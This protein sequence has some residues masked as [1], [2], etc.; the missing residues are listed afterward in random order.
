MGRALF[1][2]IRVNK[3][4]LNSIKFGLSSLYILKN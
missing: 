1:K 4:T 2:D 3:R